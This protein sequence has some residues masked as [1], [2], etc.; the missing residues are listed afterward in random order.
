MTTQDKTNMPDEPHEP[1]AVL[2]AVPATALA[3][4]EQHAQAVLALLSVVELG[5][6]VEAS[7]V[8]VVLDQLPLPG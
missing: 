4:I 5:D 1:T 8:G 2:E 6:Q 7:R 3:G